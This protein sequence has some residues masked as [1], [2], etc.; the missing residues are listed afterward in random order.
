MTK[1]SAYWRP[2]T[3]QDALALLRRRDAV[4]IGG[5]TKVNAAPDGEPVQIVDLQALGLGRIERRPG[6]LDIGAGATLAR[7]ATDAAVP[8]VVREAAR[9][10]E[11]STLRAVATLGGCV[12][13]GHWESELLAALLA[14]AATVTLAGPDGDRLV[15]LDV[16]LADRGQLAGRIITSVAIVA[17]GAAQAARTGRTQ[18]DRPIVAAV[19]RRAGGTWLALAGVSATPVLTRTGGADLADWLDRLEP[20]ADFRG[21]AEYRRALAATLARR[22]LEAVR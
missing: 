17:G 20:P 16:L 8:A 18:A 10:E 14:Y 15:S 7:I 22:V 3:V 19:A 1:V 11:P 6:G 13:A 4:L 21:S 5:G 9:R 12:A 2:A